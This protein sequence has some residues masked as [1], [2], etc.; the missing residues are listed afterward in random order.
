MIK[1]SD[2]KNRAQQFRRL[3]STSLLVAGSAFWQGCATKMISLDTN[4]E[5]AHLSLYQVTATGQET[6]FNLE[7]QPSQSPATLKLDF[8]NQVHYR[9]EA[10]RALCMPSFNTQI[11]FQDPQTA[12][13]ITLTQYK[14]DLNAIVNTP[15][16]AGDVW[17]VKPT[18][19]QTVASIDP[20]EPTLLY[21]T[22]PQPVTKNKKLDLDFPSFTTSPTA[23]VMV[24]EQ[25]TPDSSTPTGY[26][27]KL[28]K[29]P[30]E[31]G[32]NATQLTLGRKQQRYPS[33]DFSGDYVVFDS[34]DDS[35]T[36]APFE[37]KSVENE[38]SI[39]HLDHEPDTLEYYFSIAKDSVAFA[40]YG[41]NDTESTIWAAGRDGSGP[42][43]RAAGISPQLSPDGSTILYIHKPENG[44]KFRISTVNTRG[45]VKTQ[46]I[47]QNDDVDYYDPHWSPDGKLIV[48][49][50][51]SRGK[52]LP[53]DVKKEPDAAYRDAESEHS[54]IW[55]MTADG[56]HTIR[57]TRNESFDSNPVFDRN[58]KTIYFRSNRGGFWN[59]WKLDLTDAAFTQLQVAPPVQ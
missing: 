53:D 16:K 6:P 46:E 50:T 26:A 23:Q 51:P 33:F 14:L 45:P 27:S 29:L 4:P 56:Q 11:N 35:R 55:I 42:T 30:L 47:V 32:E 7:G 31:A 20:L 21:I 44:G 19:T 15:T 36:D 12:Y 43:P 52:D 24:Y 3:W 57:L 25:I 8:A 5:Q 48:F 37:F 38:A 54:F 13:N 49:C 17:Q 34:N 40:G 28:F 22:Q 58:G 1:E 59:I 41:P 9:V 39:S 18:L 10:H 2:M